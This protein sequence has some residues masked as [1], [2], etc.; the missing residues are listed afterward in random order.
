VPHGLSMRRKDDFF[1]RGDIVV[2]KGEGTL[3]CS[4]SQGA[5][6]PLFLNETFFH[7]KGRQGCS[8]V[9]IQFSYEICTVFFHRF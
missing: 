5:T 8:I 9:K 7:R 4:W 1:P 2:S 3:V 6:I